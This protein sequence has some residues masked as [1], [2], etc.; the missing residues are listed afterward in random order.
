MTMTSQRITPE[1]HEL[2]RNIPNFPRGDYYIWVR[3]QFAY[4]ICVRRQFAYVSWRWLVE[5]LNPSR[6]P[7]L[8]K[9]EVDSGSFGC[10]LICSLLRH[11]IDDHVVHKMVDI[12]PSA[13]AR[14]F[15]RFISCYHSLW[16]MDWP[17]HL[18]GHGS[19]WHEKISDVS[20]N[21]VII[22]YRF[23]FPYTFT[24]IFSVHAFCPSHFIGN[25]P[26]RKPFSIF[27][28]NFHQ[29]FRRCH[30]VVISNNMVLK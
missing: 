10:F 5:I 21:S 22:V 25:A 29:M 24:C 15:L 20:M 16:Q 4:V 8:E 30:W 18:H 26:E 3:R 28:W 17:H 7:R 13:F 6:H 14:N 19:R 11:Q 2:Q 12:K 1:F 23:L 9:A 27:S